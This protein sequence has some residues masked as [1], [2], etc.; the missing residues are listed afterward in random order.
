MTARAHR[1]ALGLAAALVVAL[2]ALGQ[3]QE[4]SCQNDFQRLSARR[5]GQIQRLNAIGKAG[6]GKM[7]PIAACPVARSLVG[8][9]TEML[10]YMVKNKEW[11]SIPDAVI[12]QFKGAREKSSKFA[13][14]ACAVAV[15]VKQMQAQQRAQATANPALQPPKLPA[16]PL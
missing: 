13:S 4:N 16:G 8:I 2:P 15:K 3:A 1:L 10:S 7:D 9:E 11:C 12:D 5:M 14:Q 6:K